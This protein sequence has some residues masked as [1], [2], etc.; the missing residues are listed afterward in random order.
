MAKYSVIVFDLGKVLVDYDYSPAIGK[1]NRIQPGLGDSFSKLYTE[2][3]E[4]HRKYER[5]EIHTEAFLDIMLERANHKLNGKQFCRLFSDVF[6]L[7]QKVIDLLPILK[8][9]YQLVL[10]SNTSIMHRKYG[11]G[12]YDFLK[13][14]SKLVLSYEVGACKPE[15]KIYQAV[16]EFTKEPS[17]KHLYIDDVKE[18]VNGAKKLGWDGILFKNYEELIKELKARKV[19]LS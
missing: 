10:L 14:F 19:S 12:S 8:K 13:Y 16:E 5:G 15:K 11:W 18:Y 7:N 2:D 1:L 6:V 3:Y 9:N 4:L 17:A